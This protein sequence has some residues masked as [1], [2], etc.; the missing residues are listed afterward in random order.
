MHLLWLFGLAKQEFGA[1]A[2]EWPSG[3][4]SAVGSTLLSTPE[5][6]RICRTIPPPVPTVTSCRIT[7]MRGTSRAIGPLRPATTA[8]RRPASYPSTPTKP[9]TASSIRSISPPAIF[10]IHCGLPPAT[11]KSRRWLVASATEILLMPLRRIRATNASHACSATET[12]GTRCVE[13]LLTDHEDG[14]THSR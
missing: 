5:A 3:L 7:S 11:A 2:Q 9:R 8:T 13:D 1:S 6:A 4:L 14:Y 10:P 12:S